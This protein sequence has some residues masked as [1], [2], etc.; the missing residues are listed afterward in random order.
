MN[1]KP[2]NRLL[3][4]SCVSKRQ[5]CCLPVTRPTFVTVS[6]WC[7]DGWEGRHSMQ[8][9]IYLT[10]WSRRWDHWLEWKMHG[11]AREKSDLILTP[12]HQ[13]G[14]K[15]VEGGSKTK[16]GAAMQWRGLVPITVRPMGFESHILVQPFMCSGVYCTPVVNL[17]P[18]YPLSIRKMWNGLTSLNSTYLS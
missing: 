12:E 1:S 18:S 11:A 2:S 5:S 13:A 3:S 8:C 6:K 9:A 15:R 4:S 14:E 16:E 10:T 7:C 17:Y